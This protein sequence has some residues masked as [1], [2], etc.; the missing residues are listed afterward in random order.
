VKLV[1]DTNIFISAFYWGG[2]PQI[3]IDRIITGLDKLFISNEILNEVIDVMSRPKFKSSQEIINR[4]VRRIEKLGTK[5]Y[6]T[7]NVTGIS[8][9][10]DDDSKIE[11]G[12]MCNADY[13]ITGDEDL[14]VLEEYNGIKIIT[15]KEYLELIEAV[16]KLQF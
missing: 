12:M 9:D 11:C 6:I 3:I 14:L 8:R 2:N 16:A 13:I 1:L 4:Y 10:K 5:I 15:P 7:G